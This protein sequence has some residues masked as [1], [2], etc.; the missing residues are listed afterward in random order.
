MG[1]KLHGKFDKNPFAPD[2]G[3]F[4]P[5]RCMSCGRAEWALESCLAFTEEFYDRV[6]V[7]KP[8]RI[9]DTKIL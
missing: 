6:D 3:L 4:F 5:Y 7:N 9:P 2:G 8:Y 1:D